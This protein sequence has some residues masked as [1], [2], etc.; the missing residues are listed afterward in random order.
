[1]APRSIIWV[2]GG[3]SG[4]G[5]TTA[6][7]LADEGADVAVSGE[8]SDVRDVHALELKRRELEG[9]ADSLAGIVYC[10][11]HNYL[12]WIGQGDGE[13]HRAEMRAVLDV[14]LLGFINMLDVVAAQSLRHERPLS[15]VAISS[16]AARRP[17]R[18]SIA[19]CASKAGLDAAVKVA[20]RELGPFGWRVNAVSPGMTGE[21]GMQ[22][23]VD[24]TVP[25]V[26]NWTE[27]RMR[28]Y[29]AEQ[30]VISGRVHKNEV[31]EIIGHTLFGPEH[32][33]GSIIEING[34]R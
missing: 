26:R 14:N 3:T 29:E 13:A 32:L 2:I 28:K 6:K 20:A 7:W 24:K 9:G 12:E 17:M 8:E 33:N 10:S 27:E 19:Y 22:A 21:T 4:I 1:M 15:V 34:G 31:A 11:G 16:D 18:T 23:Y 30:E 25:L 5:A